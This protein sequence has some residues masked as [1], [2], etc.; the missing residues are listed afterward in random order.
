MLVVTTIEDLFIIHH[1]RQHKKG[2]T[3]I[4]HKNFLNA[5]VWQHIRSLAISNNGSRPFYVLSNKQDKDLDAILQK[6]IDEKDSDYIFSDDLQRTYIMELLHF[7]TK[8]KQQQGFSVN[9]YSN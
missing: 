3:C 2:H 1:S 5:R 4:L 7:L 8:M 6:M 9:R